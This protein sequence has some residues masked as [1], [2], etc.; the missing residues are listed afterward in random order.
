MRDPGP[1]IIQQIAAD[2]HASG[3]TFMV[4]MA[5]EQPLDAEF[6]IVYTLQENNK[7]LYATTETWDNQPNLIA[8]RGYIYI[9]CDYDKDDDG[10]DIPGFKVGDGRSHLK[11]MPFADVKYAN[12]VM[13]ESI[14]ITQ[15][16]REFWNNK[17]RSYVDGTNIIFTKN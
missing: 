8:K 7:V 9:Y 6:G 17:E 4:E 1:E 16:E 11:I 14:H 2:F 13:N 10:N 15:E 3:G 5:S 12:H